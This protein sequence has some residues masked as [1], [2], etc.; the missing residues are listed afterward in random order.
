MAGISVAL[1]GP[2]PVSSDPFAIGKGRGRYAGYAD[3]LTATIP[4]WQP[5]TF[6]SQYGDVFAYAC[7]IIS[8]LV[9]LFAFFR[10]KEPAHGTTAITP[11]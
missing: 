2:P 9:C 7:V 11:A 10:T 1:P 5:H 6:Y 3:I 4:V 8:A